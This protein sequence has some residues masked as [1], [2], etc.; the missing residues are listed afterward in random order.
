MFTEHLRNQVEETNIFNGMLKDRD[1]APGFKLPNIHGKSVCSKEM[2]SSGKLVITFYGRSWRPYCTFELLACQAVYEQLVKRNVKF[3]AICPHQPGP[4]SMRRG[5]VDL[6]YE[7]LIDVD[8]E[9]ARQFG[10]TFEVPGPD[11][12]KFRKSF[13]ID[14]VSLHSDTRIELS[15]PATYIVDQDGMIVKSF[16]GFDNLSHPTPSEILKYLD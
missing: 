2:L 11:I 1:I 4:A 16:L 5:D 8:N 15:L 6:T 7:T 9:V 10:L 3:V 14:L 13:C 12:R